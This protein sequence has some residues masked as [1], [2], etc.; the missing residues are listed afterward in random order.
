[1]RLGQLVSV[2]TG[3]GDT[4]AVEDTLVMDELSVEIDGEFWAD[5]E[6]VNNA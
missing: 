4:F 2:L 3:Q 1:M 6:D 5:T